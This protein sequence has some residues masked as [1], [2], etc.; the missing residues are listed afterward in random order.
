MAETVPVPEGATLGTPVSAP[1]PADNQTQ[2]PPAAVPVPQGATL[3]TP[4][5]A[6]AP[7]APP[8]NTVPVP[9]DATLGDDHNTLGILQRLEGDA[10]I[11]WH[12][13]KDF[14]NSPLSQLTEHPEIAPEL[15]AGM[16]AGEALQ[17]HFVETGHPYLAKAAGVYSGAEKSGAQFVEGATSPLQLGIMLVTGGLGMAENI[18]A[19]TAARLGLSKETVAMAAKYAPTI[20]KLVSAG[21]SVAMLKSGYDNFPKIRE[22]FDRGDAEA[23]ANDLAST[24]AD[25]VMAAMAGIHAS[26]LLSRSGFLTTKGME[27]ADIRKAAHNLHENLTVKEGQA[28]QIQD[29]AKEHIPTSD[30]QEHAAEYIEADQNKKELG[31]RQAETKKIGTPTE[32]IDAQKPAPLNTDDFYYHA[33][34][35]SR[36]ASIEQDGLKKPWLAK[37]PEEALR[38]GAVPVNGNK[39]DL[40]VLAVPRDEVTPGK[41]DEADMGARDVEKGKYVKS[42]DVHKNF[43]QVDQTGRPIPK[44]IDTSTAIGARTAELQTAIQEAADAKRRVISPEQR[45]KMIQQQDPTREITPKA[46][47]YLDFRT[48]VMDR[49]K[50]ELQKRGLLP[51]TADSSTY[52]RHELGYDEGT[53]SLLRRAYPTMHEGQQNGIVYSNKQIGPLDAAAVRESGDRIARRDLIQDLKGGRTNEGMPLAI[54]AGYVEGQRVGT[55]VPK[56][57]QIS[58]D[59]VKARTKDGSLAKLVRSGDVV[60]DPTTKKFSFNTAKYK[61]TDLYEERPVG[62]T[63]IPKNTL[64]EMKANGHL[65]TLE[66]KGLIFHNDAGE[67]FSKEPLRA[68]VQLYAHPDA[69]DF[70]NEVMLGHN[71]TPTTFLGKFGKGY[72]D[73]TGNMKSL[74]LSWSPFHKIATLPVRLLEAFGLRDIGAAIKVIKSPPKID[75]FDLT[76]SQRAG[77]RDGLITSGY[78][79]KSGVS[80][81]LAAD[82]NSWGGKSYKIFNKTLENLGVPEK[83]RSA[84]DPQ[85][86]FTDRVFGP[87]G[88]ITKYKFALYDKMKP[89]IAD[90]MR[91]DHPEWTPA[92]VE[93][94]AGRQ[95]A[96]F[97]NNKFGGFNLML[98][99]RSL[100]DQKW[101]RRVLLAPDFLET[102]GRSVMDLTNKYGTGLT[103]RMIEFQIAHALTAAGIN[104]AIHH[105]DEDNSLEGKLKAAHFEHPFAVLSPDGKTQYSLR[106]TAGD[107]IHFLT[108]PRDFE[109]NRLNPALRA[110]REILEQRNAYGRRESWQ[111]SLE[112]PLKAVVP[113]GVQAAIPG[114]GPG[115]TTEPSKTDMV[116]KTFGVSGIPVRS[117]AEKLAIDRA[118]LKLQGTPARVGPALVKQQLK[119]NAEDKLRSALQAQKD[120]AKGGPDTVKD[121]AKVQKLKDAVENAQHDLQNLVMRKVIT[122]DD[123]KKI[124]VG[125]QGSRLK[126]VFDSLEPNDALDVWNVASD[127]EKKEL[128]L[129]MQRKYHTWLDS[130]AKNGK[131]ANN[132]T[133]PDDQA[134]FERF[135]QAR[136]KAVQLE[137]EGHQ[138]A[139]AAQQSAQ[140]PAAEK[141]SAPAGDAQPAA[142]PVPAGATLGN[143]VPVPEGA[144]LG[145]PESLKAPKAPMVYSS[146][147]Y[148]P[149]HGRSC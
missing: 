19:E 106:S 104:Y 144:E 100:Q 99:G 111:E 65:E 57:F 17:K 122:P 107:F 101:L 126:S 124:K 77:I 91:R 25:F 47:E 94:E 51:D 59:E 42:D 74:L 27:H 45:E 67:Y 63:P 137:N 108:A 120:Y 55:E 98:A 56:Q 32:Q 66:N 31:K 10:K 135:R 129:M 22:D 41:P 92:Q 9:G 62:P 128:D 110:M 12:N 24:G 121:P 117:D 115:T 49:I 149:R 69:A 125:A 79:G 105:N 36:L 2:T 97:A 136:I 4:Q 40:V 18:G 70:V 72:D 20:S 102:T 147:D 109:F 13:V 132:L 37:S 148:S 89:E 29:M 34:D 28:N 53:N 50:T 140:Q 39:A 73:I 85:K 3:E 133:E 5:A 143:A 1:A 21:F 114:L 86:I 15:T 142:V 33:V 83:V 146:K 84:I 38:S 119:F 112:A 44:P 30:A 48:K 116:L 26:Q 90:V 95:A 141:T 71:E 23:V 127:D 78:H 123:V 11:G 16:V 75:Y 80:E 130:L 68:R 113:L 139:Q 118:D 87:Q 131:S 96:E 138:E 54:P 60:Q 8:A 145:T 103:T 7:A 76:P 61:P 64:A 81:G 134:V 14:A 58:D 52:V 6:P 35:K 82:N 43:I 88:Q 46:Q 93:L